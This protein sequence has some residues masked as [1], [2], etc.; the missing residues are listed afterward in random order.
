M[1]DFHAASPASV[2]RERELTGI[3]IAG[4][5]L[6]A[7]AV[8]SIPRRFRCVFW[9]WRFWQSSQLRRPGR[10][11]RRNMIQTFRFA[12]TCSSGVQARGRI[13]ATIR[14]LNAGH[15]RP[16]ADSDV[17]PTR[18]MLAQQP[19]RDGTTDGIAT[20][21]DVI[22]PTSMT[23]STRRRLVDTRHSLYDD[24]L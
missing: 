7:A 14:W 11:G 23:R 9:L 8:P 20:S 4:L 10:L 17:T 18:I 21:T 16:D 6:C 19:R 2:A 12:C 1:D 15:R 5:F 24:G 3:N 13:A 22:R